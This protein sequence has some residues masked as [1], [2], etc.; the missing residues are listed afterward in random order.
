MVSRL[1]S[2]SEIVA[3]TRAFR[4]NPGQHHRFSVALAPGVTAQSRCDGR[5]QSYGWTQRQKCATSS[6]HTTF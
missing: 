2:L 4:G 6:I 5:S 1:R 3:E